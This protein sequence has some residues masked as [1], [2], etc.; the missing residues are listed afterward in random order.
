LSNIIGF[1]EFK[2]IS[3]TELPGFGMIFKDPD[4]AKSFGSDQI[5]KL[6]YRKLLGS[7]A[8][9]TAGRT[10]DVPLYIFLYLE[11]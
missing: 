10:M 11:S 5:I 8:R 7:E 2:F 6:I 4:L 3:D 1:S 9:R